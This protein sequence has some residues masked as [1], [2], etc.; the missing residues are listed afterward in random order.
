[1]SDGTLPTEVVGEHCRRTSRML[2]WLAALLLLWLVLGIPTGPVGVVVVFLFVMLSVPLLLASRQVGWENDVAVVNRVLAGAILAC[3]PPAV[4]AVGGLMLV[5]GGQGGSPILGTLV[6]AAGAAG[7]AYGGHV[8][9]RVA[10]I[11]RMAQGRLPAALAAEHAGVV[12]TDTRDGHRGHLSSRS[13]ESNLSAPDERSEQVR[14]DREPATGDPAHV[15]LERL[16]GDYRQRTARLRSWLAAALLPWLVISIPWALVESSATV[17]LLLAIRISPAVIALILLLSS[18]VRAWTRDSAAVSRAFWGAVIA[19]L[20][21]G[22]NALSG[23]VAL[24]GDEADDDAAVAGVSV[25]VVA[26]GGLAFAGYVALRLARVRRLAVG[27]PV[28]AASQFGSRAA[29]RP[30]IHIGFA[31]SEP[32]ESPVVVDLVAQLRQLSELR[33]LGHLTEQEFLAAKDKLLRAD[34]E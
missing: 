17:F 32:S 34:G 23:L 28:A 2:L 12:T 31:D 29:R 8:A 21:L 20:L 5:A 30:L 11:R 24:A 18:R 3:L 4:G 16:A 27:G 26:S 10:G 9:F 33:A 22:L 13:A 19:C 14:I 25:L 15:A 6:F 1:M 7:L